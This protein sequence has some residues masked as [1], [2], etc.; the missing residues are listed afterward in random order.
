M[1]H[2]VSSATSDEG[3]Q[4]IEAVDRAC[5]LEGDGEPEQ[6]AFDCEGTN[7]SRIGSVQIL[8]IYFNR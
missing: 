3:L 2:V 7:L 6:V 1:V 8:S 5:A 4:F